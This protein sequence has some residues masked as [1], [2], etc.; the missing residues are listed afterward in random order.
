M[1]RIHSR[2]VFGPRRSYWVNATN[3]ERDLAGKLLNTGELD[4][5]GVDGISGGVGGGLLLDSSSP[6]I[7]SG[8][9]IGLG[10][11]HSPSNRLCVTCNN[12]RASGSN[13]NALCTIT[14]RE[15]LITLDKICG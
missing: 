15:I 1:M 2:N 11:V 8:S 9:S 12:A 14:N 6:N 7:Y 13:K 5:I 4:N 3:G 10:P